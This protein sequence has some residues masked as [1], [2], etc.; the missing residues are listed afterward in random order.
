MTRVSIPHIDCYYS[1]SNFRLAHPLKTLERAIA[2]L[3]DADVK[4]NSKKFATNLR[5]LS[6][7]L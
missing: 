1:P 7:I 5:N 2:R 6:V 4:G 3:D